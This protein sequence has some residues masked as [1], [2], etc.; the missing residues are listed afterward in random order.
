M[1]HERESRPGGDTGAASKSL[2]GDYCHGTATL[3]QTK[4]RRA[5]AQ[6]LA[7]QPSGYADPWRYE[8]P[9]AGYLEAAEHLLSQ[10]LTPAPDLPAMRLMWQHGGAEQRLAIE[11]AERWAVVA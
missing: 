7:I 2:G 5:A 8:P 9:T 11:I 4:L 1:T 3:R 6:R 10:G